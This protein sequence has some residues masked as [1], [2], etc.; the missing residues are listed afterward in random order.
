MDTKTREGLIERLEAMRDQSD[1]WHSYRLDY[2]QIAA[3]E[4]CWVLATFEGLT[5]EDVGAFWE[6]ALG[7]IGMLPCLLVEAC[8]RP[9][10][11]A[12][13]L[14]EVEIRVG[15][16]SGERAEVPSISLNCAI[17]HVSEYG[18]AAWPPDDGRNI[19]PRVAS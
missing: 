17:G 8:V 7:G 3:L 15:F 10:G 14:W 13:G 1:R 2:G 19:T 5:L 12:Q 18:D 9:D 6:D 4:N 16:G 11:D